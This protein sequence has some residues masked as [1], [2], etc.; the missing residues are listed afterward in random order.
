MPRNERHVV[1]SADGWRVV[2]PGASRASATAGT[3]AEATQIAKRILG[4]DGG[5]EAVIHRPN[6]RIR[7]SDTVAPGND[8]F[9]P[10]G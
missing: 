1:P 10:E 6:G 4:N 7:G 5:G 2:K 9:P 8:P 3:Q